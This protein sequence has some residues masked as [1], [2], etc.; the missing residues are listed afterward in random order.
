MGITSYIITIKGNSKSSACLFEMDG[1]LVCVANRWTVPGL[2]NKIDD[3]IKYIDRDWYRWIEWVAMRGR[4]VPV[5]PHYRNGNNEEN[6][7]T[8]SYLLRNRLSSV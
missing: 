5:K 3:S 2:Y 8:R 4:L 1:K 7:D 6:K